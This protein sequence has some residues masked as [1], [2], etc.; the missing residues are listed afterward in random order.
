MRKF[1]LVAAAVSAVGFAVPVT[2]AAYAN[3]KVIIKSGHHDNGRHLGWYRGRHEGWRRAHA[4]GRTKVIIKK[5][6]RFD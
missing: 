1:A 2:T 5:H 4:E 6:H 3:E